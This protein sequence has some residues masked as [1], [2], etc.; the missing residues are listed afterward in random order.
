M[1]QD[2]PGDQILKRLTNTRLVGILIAAGTVVI[3]LS[4]FTDATKNLVGLL[5]R[6]TPESA[7]A[8]LA[9]LAVP[10]TPQAF[11]ERTRKGDVPVVK[12]FVA[13]GM[14]PNAKDD[15]G[16]TALMNAIAE[17]RTEVVNVLLGAKA[18]VNEKNGGGATALDW[19]AARGQ[20][21]TVQL[22]LDKGAN[23]DA[24]NE[25]VVAAAEAG[26]T[27][28]IRLLLEKGASAHDIGARA[29]LAAAGST[30]VGV[31][32]RDLSETARLLLS[33][34]V[35][36]NAKDNDGWTA[37]LMAADQNRSAVA[38]TLLDAGADVNARCE[39]S[40]YLLGGWTALMIASREGRVE[41]VKML[42]AKR[43]DV[44]IRNNQG[45]TA[46]KVATRR[47]NA[48]VVRLLRTHGS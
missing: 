48:E 27:D 7:R 1:P 17:H 2:S 43:A 5:K 19:A 38:Q 13:A 41:L 16:N 46:L 9:G 32:D 3:A 30:V 15:E 22:L 18:D 39:C 6:E 44:D 36:V 12:L 8:E 10:Y 24:V 20:R 47:G 26:H 21:D 25:G 34:G 11:V 45:E 33:L 37:L 4:T 23:R 40:G 42:L 29:L 28:I 35:D 31:E 14:D